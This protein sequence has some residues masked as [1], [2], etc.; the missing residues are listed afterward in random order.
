MIR[1]AYLSVQRLHLP[2]GLVVIE[3]AESRVAVGDAPGQAFHIVTA[4]NPH[5]R[6]ATESDNRRAQRAQIALLDVRNAAYHP[7]A[8]ADPAWLHV[9]PSVAISGLTRQEAVDL[10]WRFN[11]DAIFEWTADA[12]TVLPCTDYASVALGWRQITPDARATGADRAWRELGLASPYV[13]IAAAN[14][15][16][17]RALEAVDDQRAAVLNYVFLDFAADHWAP[18]VEAERVRESRRKE[19]RHE[20]DRAAAAAARRARSDARSFALVSRRHADA[21]PP[22]TASTS[23]PGDPRR[24]GRS[25]ST[26]G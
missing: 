24:G 5:G 22:S 2:V 9:E 23:K 1:D 21:M 26:S 11:Q 6:L 10:G 13:S 19:Q 25:T 14:T 8:G 3:S 12:L 15:A 7:A 18:P 17:N 16:L 4:Y 20:A